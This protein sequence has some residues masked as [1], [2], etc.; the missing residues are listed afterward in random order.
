MRDYS[1]YM[2]TVLA[3]PASSKWVKVLEIN[4]SLTIEYSQNQLLRD[5]TIDLVVV[6][7]FS[8]ARQ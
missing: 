1:I 7:H 5:D 4:L 2:T 6:T 3:L 8:V